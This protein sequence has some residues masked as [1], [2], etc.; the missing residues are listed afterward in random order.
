[1]KPR[2]PHCLALALAALPS[3]SLA[4]REEPSIEWQKRSTTIA[5]GAVPV[6]KHSLAD[7]PV[8]GDWRLGMNLASTWT[9]EMPILIGE[10]LLAPGVYRCNLVRLAE[11]KCAVVANGSGI[12][13]GGGDDIRVEGVLAKSKKAGKKLELGWEK[14]AADGKDKSV[15]PVMLN[16]GFGEDGWSGS[17]QLLG[18][19]VK[20]LGRWELTVFAVPAAIV[21]GREQAR[22]P[23]AVLSRGKGKELEC[24]NVLLSGHDA[25]L[26]PWMAAPTEQFGFGAIVP[27]DEK[28]TTTGTV[29]AADAAV[30]KPVA[31]L[32]LANAAIKKGTLEV[33][34]AVDK[35][36]LKVSLPEPPAR[37]K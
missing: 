12:A 33:E 34:F 26:V 13:L 9:V 25:R 6:G 36:T 1:M 11:D 4:Q 19:E 21:A 16:I 29:E 18:G 22:V 32:K 27:P 30:D 5:Y 10:R 2:T 28:K 14:E 35:Q 17:M 7:L 24:W 20:K 31:V 15:L 8:G 37:P 23:V 3:F